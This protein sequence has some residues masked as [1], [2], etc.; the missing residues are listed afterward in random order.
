MRMCMPGGV[1][2]SCRVARSALDRA[3]W[4][5]PPWQ[6]S[7]LHPGVLS[8]W[9]L[10]DEMLGGNTVSLHPIQGGVEMLLVT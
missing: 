8:K 1:L 4:V 9:V 3:V 2:D 10:A 5:R 6:S 7:S